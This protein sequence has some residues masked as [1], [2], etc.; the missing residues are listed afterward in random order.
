[1]N[2]NY[3]NQFRPI[4]NTEKEEAADDG[5]GYLVCAY[6]AH[7]LCVSAAMVCSILCRMCMA[8]WFMTAFVSVFVGLC[9]SI[10]PLWPLLVSYLLWILCVDNS[11]DHGGRRN[12]WFRSIRFW[13]YFADYYPAS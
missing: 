10:P 13:R 5:C 12:P 4:E 9:R 3:S 7:A 8:C 11:S 6:A 2:T 1:M